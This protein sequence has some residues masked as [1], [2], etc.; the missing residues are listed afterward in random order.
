MTE[1]LATLQNKLPKGRGIK[2][3][4]LD[5]CYTDEGEKEAYDSAMQRIWDLL[6]QAPALLT[7]RVQ[8]DERRVVGWCR[9]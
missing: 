1:Y 8:R 5:S 9:A 4:L 2:F 3:L 6:G 7:V